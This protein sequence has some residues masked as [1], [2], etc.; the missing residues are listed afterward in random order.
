VKVVLVDADTSKELVKKFK[1]SGVPV[2]I[3]FRDGNEKLRH[4]G[5]I[6]KKELMNKI[7]Q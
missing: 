3:I 4:V 5:M 7:K 1:V 2:F 6:D